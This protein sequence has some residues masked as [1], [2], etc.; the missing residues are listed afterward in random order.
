MTLIKPVP[1]FTWTNDENHATGIS[2]IRSNKYFKLS[3]NL[4]NNFS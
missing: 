3:V 4:S 1:K 2:F